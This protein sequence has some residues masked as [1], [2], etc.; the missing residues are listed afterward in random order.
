MA[1]KGDNLVADATSVVSGDSSD[2]TSVLTE[3]SKLAVCH[4]DQCK[5]LIILDR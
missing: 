4:V 3:G 2:E 5:T 1:S